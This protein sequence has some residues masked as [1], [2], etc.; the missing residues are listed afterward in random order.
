[1][2]NRPV[3]SSLPAQQ[4]SYNT[5]FLKDR[6]PNGNT[7]W[8]KDTMD[9]LES[10]GRYG[11]FNNIEL[12]KNYEIV[13]GRFDINDYVD[14]FDTY[15]LA[16]VVYQEMK[17]PSF[18]KHYDITTKATKLI[19]GEFIKRPDIIQV[20]AKDAETDNEKLRI[21]T[22]LVYDYVKQAVNQEITKKL[23][24]QGLDPNK[25]EFKSEEEAS[26]YKEVIQQKYQEL[27][28]KSIEK[29]MR[30]DFRTQAEH[31]GNAVLSNSIERFR[32]KEQDIIE[33]ND[34]LI[35]DRAFS[36]IFLTPK[37][38]GI[39]TWNPL[40]VFHQYNVQNRNIEDLGYVGRILYMTKT[41]IIDY[42]G[43][44]MTVSQIESLYPEYQK[45][46]SQG[47]VFKEAFNATLYPFA[48]Y[49]EY[50]TLVTAVGQAVGETTFG[51]SPFG[52]SQFGFSPGTDG[53]N[54][55]FTQAD[56]VQVTQAY[57]KSQRKVGKVI[58]Q[59]P[60]IG[61][62]SVEIV[63]ETF[64]PKL[65]GIKVVKESFKDTD[66]PNTIAWTWITETWQGIKIAVNHERT[67]NTDDRNSIYFDIKPC[68]FQFR[69]NDPRMIHE[70]KLPVC[71][72]IFNNRNGRS[73]SL[74]DLLKPY[75][76]LHNAFM[77]QAYQ[78][79]QKGNGKF[80]VI[81][82]S[83]IPSVKGMGGEDAQE[84]FTT[85][86]QN[87]G[88]VLVD[89]STQGL[90][91][92]MQ[93]G[94]KVLDLDESDRI[95]RLIN[96]S[97]LVEQQGFMQLGITPQ[98]QGTVSASET[99]TG[100]QTAVSNSYAI[101]EIYFENFSN[102]RRRK[103]QMLLEM[104]QYVESLG[105]GDINL[106]YTTSDLGRA[107]IQVNKTDIML[108]D[109]GVYVMNSA[110][111]QRKKQ[112]VED[113]IL[114]QNQQL[115]PLSELINIIKLDN[116]TDIQK[117]LAEKEAEQQQQQQAQQ[118]Q[119]SEMQQQQLQAQAEEK[120]KDRQLKKYEIDTKASTELQKASLQG[121]ANE[122]SYNPDLDLTDKLIAQK[123]MAIKEQEVNSKNYLAQQQLVNQQLE[124][125]RK[126]KI[127][128]EKMDSDKKI[129]ESEQKNRQEIEKQK[130]EQ[131]KTQNVSQ[132]KINKEANAAKIELANKQLEMKSLEMKMKE[133][134]LSNAKTKS[135][136]EINHLKT[137]VEIEKDLAETKVDAIEMQTEAKIKEQRELSKLKSKEAEQS[138]GFKMEENT[139]A[140][141]LKLKEQQ[142]QHKEKLKQIKIKPK[143][144]KPKK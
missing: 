127:E 26:E 83:L 130:L 120:E 93:Y 100:T 124:S 65:F 59:D 136:I 43:W 36:H 96:L 89:D 88:F 121:I 81:G 18:L 66:E 55:I 107:F 73:M 139:Q 131:I 118:Q 126:G 106:S 69:G 97:M 16:S 91:A 98:R 125:Y 80:A 39:E 71:G 111:Q 60:D 119:Q 7:K 75:Q 103:L 133:M 30:Y 99:A 50:D 74:V 56:I 140:H 135:N 13:Q 1:M 19:T 129:K 45:D 37:G 4:V 22:E 67:Q 141:K 117:S 115:M 52:I 54:Y 21:K 122:S 24:Q 23:M 10:V 142:E 6:D 27:T 47:S 53:T 128:K 108:K 20:V 25:D 9:A 62:T 32:I 41:E 82:A 123:D 109:L 70:C 64:D 38:Y 31:W 29:Y 92:S 112:I 114:R 86:A 3:N 8:M 42:F 105:E 49:R 116:L 44:R 134:E 34:Y 138:T 61:E 113:L 46:E 33:L 79:G 28:P 68:E 72:S 77:N 12:R 2:F 51:G 63:D 5:K 14:V 143:I 90:A 57:W 15:D 58:L 87:L 95:T 101:T 94:L 48:D 76:V 40:T 11:M 132:E 78:V 144:N 85:M 35:S 137:K 104:V 17:L 110:D 102:Y 84:K